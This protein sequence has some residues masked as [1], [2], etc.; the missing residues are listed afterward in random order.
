ME[1]ASVTIC[2]TC[3]KSWRGLFAYLPAHE[4]CIKGAVWNDKLKKYEYPRLRE[5][6]DDC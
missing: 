2:G 5:V 1:N 4:P 6:S 3:K